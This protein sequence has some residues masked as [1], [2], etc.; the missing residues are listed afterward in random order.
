MLYIESNPTYRQISGTT[1]PNDEAAQF[2]LLQ[3][4]WQRSSTSHCARMHAKTETGLTNFVS[5]PHGHAKRRCM[6]N[7]CTVL[8]ETCIAS[9]PCPGVSLLNPFFQDRHNK[10]KSG[11][12]NTS[13]GTNIQVNTYKIQVQTP[14]IQVRT[15][16][17]QVQTTKIQVHTPK[18]LV[19]GSGGAYMP[20]Y[21][22]TKN[23]QI[24]TKYIYIYIY[25]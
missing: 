6:T 2:A 15:Q 10:Y 24:A 13:P 14:K 9:A 18:I 25:V 4:P 11:H 1:N 7:A 17:I 22:K 3:K 8:V 20:G 21:Y 12:P 19:L 5:T 23:L 16:Q